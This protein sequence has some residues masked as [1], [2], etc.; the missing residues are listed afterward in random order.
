MNIAASFCEERAGGLDHIWIA[1]QN[2]G[3]HKSNEDSI[4]TRSKLLSQ[5]LC[6]FFSCYNPHSARCYFFSLSLMFGL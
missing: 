1:G 4:E 6:S 5:K 3:Q 2:K